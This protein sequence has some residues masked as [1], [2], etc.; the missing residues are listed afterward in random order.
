MSFRNVTRHT[1]VAN[2]LTMPGTPRLC[3][4]LWVKA[5]A[6]LSRDVCKF[7]EPGRP[8][9]AFGQSAA[10]GES[11]T[12]QSRSSRKTT[13][14]STLSE[15]STFY[16][17]LERLAQNAPSLPDDAMDHL[18]EARGVLRRVITRTPAMSEADAAAK[19]RLAALLMEDPACIFPEDCALVTD[20]LA[21]LCNA[22]GVSATLEV[23]A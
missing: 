8:A 12:L 9:L 3:N 7:P 13:T 15:L 16:A 6:H 4:S 14:M 17:A 2:G 11:P 19:L 20:A 5:V 1:V 10:N 21:L 23:I 18:T 22:R